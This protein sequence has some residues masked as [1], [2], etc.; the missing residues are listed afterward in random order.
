MGYLRRYVLLNFLLHSAAGL[1]TL[2]FAYRSIHGIR[3]PPTPGSGLKAK[4]QQMH[5]MRQ[6]QPTGGRFRSPARWPRARFI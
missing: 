5:R 6:R 1:S 3:R 4:A 2:L